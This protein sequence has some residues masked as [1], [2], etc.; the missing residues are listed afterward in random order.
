MKVQIT[1]FSLDS[2]GINSVAQ[3]GYGPQHDVKCHKL[4]PKTVIV[5]KHTDF[6]SWECQPTFSLPSCLLSG[7]AS[8]RETKSVIYPCV[9][10]KCQ[11]GCPC[12]ICME[13]VDVK[14]C[15]IQEYYQSHQMY[16]HAAHLSCEFCCQILITFPAFSYYKRKMG[17]KFVPSWLFSHTYGNIDCKTKMPRRARNPDNELKTCDECNASFK[18]SFNKDRHYMNVHYKQKYECSECKQLFGRQDNLKK[19]R[20]YVHEA[21]KI[22]I[23]GDLNNHSKDMYESEDEDDITENVL[24]EDQEDLEIREDSGLNSFQWKCND[25]DKNFSSKF[26]LGVHK[27]KMQQCDN[28]DKSFCSKKIMKVHMKFSHGINPFECKTCLEKFS[29]KRNLNRHEQARNVA[30]CNECGAKFCNSRSM[31]SHQSKHWM[32]NFMKNK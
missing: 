32:A 1:C 9:Y 28:C 26:N 7:P 2:T 20:R 4:T 8:L 5:T 16:H 27:K 14:K 30:T 22:N 25:C 19:H 31:D 29:S 23:G 18:T 3:H 10:G 13:S 17:E 15:T 12:I 6:K 11:V 24:E 21:Q